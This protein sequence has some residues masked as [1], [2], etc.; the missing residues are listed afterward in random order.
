MAAH[1]EVRQ[2]DGSRHVELQ[3]DRVTL[4][5]DPANA[6]CVDDDLAAQLADWRARLAQA[7]APE[8]APRIA[9]AR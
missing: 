5:R 2:S 1:L 9:T 3:G 8:R 4:G 6:V 7:Y